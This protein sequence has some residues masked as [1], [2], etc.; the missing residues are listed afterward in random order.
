MPIAV[1]TITEIVPQTY[2]DCYDLIDALTTHFG[3]VSTQ[4]NLV[5]VTGAT[6]VALVIESVADPGFQIAMY[7]EGPTL[8]VSIHTD[9]VNGIT[10]YN[11]G[12]WTSDANDISPEG[13]WTYEGI[14]THAIQAIHLVELDDAIFLMCVH[15]SNYWLNSFHVGRIYTPDFPDADVPLGRD[16]LG[17]LLNR[18]NHGSGS[19]IWFRS[20]GFATNECYIRSAYGNWLKVGNVRS[21][22]STTQS[23]TADS[24]SY[25]GFLRPYAAGAS[26]VLG[27]GSTSPD[28][29]IGRYKYITFSGE[30]FTELTRR[31][32]DNATDQS[33]IAL[34][35][36]YVS[37]IW[38]RGYVP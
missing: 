29:V 19:A 32:L 24:S 34:T 33:W 10:A 8:N 12:V 30:N 11:Q 23:T 2:E 16:G 36:S 31:D 5:N 4:W 6:S 25:M 38:R 14:N 20:S 3:S 1:P 15:Q 9:F 7:T 35:A 22:F 26:V 18:P 21:P 28:G 27:T 17:L 13:V 37:M